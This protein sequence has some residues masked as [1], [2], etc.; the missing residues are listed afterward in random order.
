MHAD[1][2]AC[3]Q[4]VFKGY[5]V[6]SKEFIDIVLDKFKGLGQKRWT[7]GIEANKKIKEHIVTLTNHCSRIQELAHQVT[8][9][10]DQRNYPVAHSALDDIEK[11]VHEIRRHLD[12]LQNVLDF[13]ARPAGG[14]DDF[15]VEVTAS[16]KKV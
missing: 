11:K 2:Y 7:N 13:C 12:H 5:I 8:S 6:T 9:H 4:A 14:T 16:E 15:K 3:G 1:A 10:A